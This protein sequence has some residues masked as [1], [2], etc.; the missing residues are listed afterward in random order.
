MR[1]RIRE[2]RPL[3]Y[4]QIE[5]HWT[6]CHNDQLRRDHKCEDDAEAYLGLTYDDC[7]NKYCSGSQNSS[8]SPGEDPWR[9]LEM[10]SV[11][12]AEPA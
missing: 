3:G 2:Y 10:T 7:E 9:N 12:I 11:S 5:V 4:R 6:K 1:R 8:P